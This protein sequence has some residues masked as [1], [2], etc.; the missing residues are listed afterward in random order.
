VEEE[1]DFLFPPKKICGINFDELLIKSENCMQSSSKSFYHYMEVANPLSLHGRL[2][3]TPS[4][5]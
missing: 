2:I 5:P 4:I 3:H 1:K